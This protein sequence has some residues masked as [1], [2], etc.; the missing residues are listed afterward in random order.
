MNA[1]Q[2]QYSCG[3]RV[4]DRLRLKKELVTTDHQGRP[5]GEI[6]TPGEVWTVT[7]DCCEEEHD[8]WLLQPDGSPHTWDDDQSVFDYF[9]RI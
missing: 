2:R 3:L 8:L 4:G 6:H 9:D 5:T 1:D 7:D